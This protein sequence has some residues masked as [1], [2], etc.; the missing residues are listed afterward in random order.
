M[1][2]K[3]Y[4]K[5]KPKFLLT[6]EISTLLNGVKLNSFWYSELLTNNYFTT[7]LVLE[8]LGY[9]AQ[10]SSIAEIDSGEYTIFE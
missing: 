5:E 10:P 4:S 9:R 1:I 6:A 8:L 3:I 2:L 7:R